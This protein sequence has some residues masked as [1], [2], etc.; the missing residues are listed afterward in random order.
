MGTFWGWQ[1][2]KGLFCF[3]HLGMCVCGR[4]IC[5]W[6]KHR[7]Q[8]SQFRWARTEF[9]SDSAVP[10]YSLLLPLF[11][12]D[13]P[14]VY[15]FNYIKSSGIASVRYKVF[16]TVIVWISLCLPWNRWSL[17]SMLNFR[18]CC[19]ESHTWL[20]VLIGV[21]RLLDSIDIISTVLTMHI[22]SFSCYSNFN[23]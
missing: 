3:T 15:M 21:E 13:I 2:F 1:Q 10:I 6:L 17:L 9:S 12:H 20:K 5:R 16:S 14:R 7:Y 19:Q 8:L 22:T 23:Y 11:I 4:K 18:S